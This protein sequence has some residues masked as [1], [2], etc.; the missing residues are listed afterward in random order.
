LEYDF[1]LQPGANPN[2]IS[3]S[4][5]GSERVSLN[6]RG[7]LVLRIGEREMSFLRPVTYQTSADGKTR[8]PVE[9]RYVIHPSIAGA[10]VRVT[11]ALGAYD[12][13]R[14]L[15]IDPAVALAYSQYLD[16]YAGSVAV[17]SAGNT[18]VAG[19]LGNST[20]A[21]YLTK[22]S[23]TGAVLYNNV[24]GSGGNVYVYGI[25]VDSTNKVYVAGQAYYGD[26][27]P[28][29]TNAYS[30]TNTASY[31]AFHLPNHQRRVSNYRWVFL[32]VGGQI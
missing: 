24:F 30:R 32:L 23:P 4:L 18:Y 29:S 25:A 17:D 9:G 7:D 31:S 6:A 27:L 28:V 3:L 16:S 11:F 20:G 12:H 10:P 15:V 14:T 5:R 19:P 2:Q 13:A 8:Q 22:F 1:I 26:V 21:L